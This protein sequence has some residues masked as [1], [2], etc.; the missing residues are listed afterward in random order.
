MKAPSSAAA[1]ATLSLSANARR[2]VD[3]AA[4]RVTANYN[5]PSG[6]EGYIDIRLV[7]VT[8]NVVAQGYSSNTQPLICDGA[9][10]KMNISVVVSNDYP[11]KA[12]RAFGS[13]FLY[14]AASETLE[15]TAAT[16]RTITIS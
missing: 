10:H 6:T 8:G 14:A 4:A 11:F 5:C 3:G 2:L 16:Q 9:V 15:A 13:G 1:E 12:G 7:E